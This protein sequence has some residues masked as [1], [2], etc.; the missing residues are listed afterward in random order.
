[1]DWLKVFKGRDS[2]KK[3]HFWMKYRPF[4]CIIDLFDPF[5]SLPLFIL[6]CMI[7]ISQY[8]SLQYFSQYC[9]TDIL[10]AGKHW[11]S[12]LIL[13]ERSYCLLYLY[14]ILNTEHWTYK[15]IVKIFIVCLKKKPG[16]VYCKIKV[17]F[18]LNTRCF[19]SQLRGK[20]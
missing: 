11:E 3:M 1:M 20:N 13:A 10:V 7:N 16:Q 6:L 4:C 9:Y 19:N 12:A 14:C 2:S 8:I 15:T 17:Y 5:F 18:V